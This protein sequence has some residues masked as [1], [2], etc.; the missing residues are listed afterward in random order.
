ME[1][2]LSYDAHVMDMLCVIILVQQIVTG[3][4][5]VLGE[6]VADC[7]TLSIERLNAGVGLY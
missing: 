7:V 6:D 3:V 2:I 1:S 5:E 4:T